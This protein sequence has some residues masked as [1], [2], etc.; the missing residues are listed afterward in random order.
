MPEFLGA[1]IILSI[2]KAFYVFRL[3]QKKLE[4]SKKDLRSLIVFIR[5]FRNKLWL[6]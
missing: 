5:R 3:R 6:K 1:E 2:V 4:P